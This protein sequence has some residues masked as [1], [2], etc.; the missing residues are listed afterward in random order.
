MNRYLAMLHEADKKIET[1]QTDTLQ[2]LQN[3]DNGSFVGFEGM[4][5]SEYENLTTLQ[6]VATIQTEHSAQADA[7]DRYA[8]L[9]TCQQCEHLAL[10]GYCKVKVSV[11]PSPD[12]M[13]V[14]RSFELVQEAR[15][16]IA[17]NPYT[18]TELEALLS[19]TE[20]PLFYHLVACKACDVEA[21]RYCLDGYAM[22][23][24]YDDLLLVFE[25]AA[26][27]RDALITRMTKARLSG[28]REFRSAK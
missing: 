12:A 5:S 2:N 27:K 8:H 16:P 17:N 25:D 4:P 3:P 24:A 26:N 22:G 11:K 9:I 13:H 1:H 19:K 10:S 18:Q 7:Q 15:A 14:C 20:K 28:R 6:D 23:Q 21:S